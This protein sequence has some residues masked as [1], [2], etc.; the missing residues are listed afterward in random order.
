MRQTLR[1][2]LALLVAGCGTASSPAT[3]AGTARPSAAPPTATAASTRA[4]FP[5]AVFAG[6]TDD[7]VSDD[8][9][10][11]LQAALA[12]HDVTGGGGMSATVMTAEGTW[13]GAIGKADGVRDVAV[14]DQ[15][16]I[17]SITKPVVAA[18]VLLLVEAGKLG[19]DDPVSAYLPAD[20]GFDTNG[21]TIRQLLGHRS[22]LPDDYDLLFDSVATEPK[23]IWTPAEILRLLPPERVPPGTSFS[24]AETN[25]LVLQLAIEHVRGRPL[26]EVLRDGGALAVDGLD[27]LVY[28]PDEQ[29]TGHIAMPRGAASP[30]LEASGGYVPSLATVSAHHASGAIASDSLSLARW[31]RALCAGDIV[32][33]AS[34]TE[35]STF[36]PA[37]NLDGYGLGLYNPAIGYATGFGHTG[38]L[39]GY[40]S[41]AACLPDEGA[42]IVVLTNHYVDDG[43]WAYSH[44]LARPLVAAIRQL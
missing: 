26:V 12:T 21:A 7:P 13:S 4:P 18:Q 34:L 17:A 9:A 16:A 15:F 30:D 19:L 20:L 35:M 28:Q 36:R 37:P 24:Y 27:R 2:C 31:W 8:V 3:P 42:V 10:A 39:P 22:G 23:R 43:Q 38:E 33:Q 25:Y 11:R 41:W 14:D 29:P 32:S 44:G 40:M 6:V 1:L 5:I